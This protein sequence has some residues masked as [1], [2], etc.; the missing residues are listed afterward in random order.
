MAFRLYTSIVV[1]QAFI[2]VSTA[3]CHADRSEVGEKIY[4]T[5][6]RPNAIIDLVQTQ[7]TD[8]LEMVRLHSSN[9][10]KSDN[11]SRFN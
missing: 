8:T 1:F 3:F 7:S 2:H 10:K 6:Y 11:H 9:S 5:E 4:P